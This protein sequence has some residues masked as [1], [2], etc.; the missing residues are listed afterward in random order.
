[1]VNG[2]LTSPKMVFTQKLMMIMRKSVP[3]SRTSWISISYLL[4][5]S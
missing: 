2:L 1:L 3:W 4:L 5:M